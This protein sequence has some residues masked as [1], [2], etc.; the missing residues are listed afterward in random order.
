MKHMN[1]EAA[2]NMRKHKNTF[3]N[4]KCYQRL[5]RKMEKRQK[6]W[7]LKSYLLEQ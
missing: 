4:V 2:D 3:W 7:N 5:I 6:N 1:E